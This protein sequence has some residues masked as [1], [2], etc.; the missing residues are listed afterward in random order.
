M[1]DFE[2]EDVANSN[3]CMHSIN[4]EIHKA[5]MFDQSDVLLLRRLAVLK[6]WAQ[7]MAFPAE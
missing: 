7:D 5:V 1:T 4:N 2:R 6:I 3:L